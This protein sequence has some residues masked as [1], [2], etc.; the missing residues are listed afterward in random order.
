MSADLLIGIHSVDAALKHDADNIVELYV[1]SGS[2]NARI[3]ELVDRAKR[4]R[5]GGG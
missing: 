3:K 2:A 1:E 5:G 4:E